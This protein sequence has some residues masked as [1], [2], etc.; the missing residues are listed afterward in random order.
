MN[1]TPEIPGPG[2]DL[3]GIRVRQRSGMPSTRVHPVTRRP[4]L[5]TGRSPS[6]ASMTKG[7][8]ALVAG[9]PPGSAPPAPRSHKCPRA[10]QSSSRPPRPPPPARAARRRSPQGR[11]PA[12]RP[13]CLAPAD[14]E[15]PDPERLFRIPG[16][17]K[18][19]ISFTDGPTRHSRS[20]RRQPEAH[21]AYRSIPAG[22]HFFP[23][24][25]RACQPRVSRLWRRVVTRATLSVDEIKR[26]FDPSRRTTLSFCSMS[27]SDASFR[28]KLH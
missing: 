27:L 5:I 23:S 9:G 4:P 2:H 10:E 20:F 6:R 21:E 3:E 13:T 16:H 26:A 12:G 18:S 22:G 7:C 11:W 19:L 17:V 28:T 1:E 24:D 14:W 25:R 15:C 8:R